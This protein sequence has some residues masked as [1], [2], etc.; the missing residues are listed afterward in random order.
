MKAFLIPGNGE[1]LKTRNY[2]GVLDLYK[3]FGYEAV[4]VPIHWKYKTIN[5]WT[6]Q[7]TDFICKE[8]LQNS[9]LSGFSFGSII[10]FSVAAQVNPRRLLLFSLSPYFQEDMPWPKKYEEWAGKRRTQAFRKLY[11]NTLAAEIKCPTTIF[12]GSKEKEKYQDMWYRSQAAHEK[13]PNSKLVLV[14]GVAHDVGDPHY[15]KAIE[16]IL[17][18]AAD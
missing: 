13:I 9:L 16:Q 8:D 14:K 7:V 10:A 2:Q 17:K 1:N 18:Q 11:F 12:L 4:F 3:Q 5:D 15:I 6:K